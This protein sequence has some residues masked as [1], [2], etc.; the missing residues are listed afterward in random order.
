[1]DMDIPILAGKTIAEVGGF[2]LQWDWTQLCVRWGRF[3][4]E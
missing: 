2:W 4:Q 1:M 3:R